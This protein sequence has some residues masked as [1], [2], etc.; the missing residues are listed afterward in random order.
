MARS[1]ARLF[2]ALLLDWRTRR[3]LS[4]LDL[5]LA[6][7]VSPRH[8][9]FLETG[10]AQPSRK[11]ALRLGCALGIPLR[12][13]NTM[14]RAAGFPDEFPEPSI[15]G[16]LP[17]GVAHAIE[18]MLAQHEPFPLVVLDR[19]YQVLQTNKGATR[20]FARFIAD[21]SAMPPRPNV[22]AMLFDPRLVRPFV[23]DWDHVARAVTARLHREAL[24]RSGD[25]DIAALLRSLFEYPGV[26]G[27]WRRPDFSTPSE[28]TLTLR[29]RRDQ[30]EVAFLTTLT[31]FNAPQNVTLEELCIESY[32]PLDDATV[33][34]C[35]SIA[36]GEQNGP[37]ETRDARP[38]PGFR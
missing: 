15:E 35:T 1:E 37:S 22:F 16:G 27:T 26:P 4:Q 20:L 13:Q 21:P 29:L 24:I 7:D 25:S 9:S 33:Q 11:M 18:R 6:A 30:L 34:T 8:V 23:V 10:R 31:I 38:L 19:R 12:D 14:L 17:A 2:P 5:A 32:F 36:R 28:P 3:G